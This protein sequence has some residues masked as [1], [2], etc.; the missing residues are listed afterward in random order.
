MVLTKVPVISSNVRGT[1]M[2]ASGSRLAIAASM[3]DD[4][5]LQTATSSSSSSLRTLVSLSLPV[6]FGSVTDSKILCFQATRLND[7]GEVGSPKTS[8][9]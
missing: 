3:Y 5:L 7:F 9:R 4:V 6:I 1:I 2:A 8:N